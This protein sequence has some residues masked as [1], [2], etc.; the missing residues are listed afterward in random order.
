MNFGEI[1]SSKIWI[2]GQKYSVA[3]R[4]KSQLLNFL[5]GQAKL[6]VYITRKNKIEGREGQHV[7]IVFKNMVK[8]RVMFDFKFY[9]LMNDLESF[10]PK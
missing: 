2:L 4:V 9:K 8:A 5:I 6:A 7:V 10:L 1:F 3:Q